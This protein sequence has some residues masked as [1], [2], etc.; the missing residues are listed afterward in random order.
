MWRA[1][2]RSTSDADLTSTATKRPSATSELAPPA[3]PDVY[4]KAVL[5]AYRSDEIS[6][7]R[8]LG[9]L[10]DTWAEEDLPDLPPLPAEAIASFVS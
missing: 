3:L 5:N 9:L 10:L 6:A 2:R 4:V 7:A 1:S 8:A